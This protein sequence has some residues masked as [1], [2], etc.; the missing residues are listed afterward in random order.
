MAGL[1]MEIDLTA[2]KPMAFA[3]LKIVELYVNNSGDNVCVDKQPDGTLLFNFES[4]KAAAAANATEVK[5]GYNATDKNPVDEFV[6]S[7]CGFTC[8][9]YV[10][11]KYDEDGD[12]TYN[13]EY[14]FKHCPNCG[15]KMEA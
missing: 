6:C 7:N 13:C 1:T 5:R 3:A 11:V 9:D 8:A 12:Y 4:D 15:A 2:G 14:E 10:Q